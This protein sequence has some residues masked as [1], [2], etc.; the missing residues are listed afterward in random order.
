MRTD[1]YRY[2]TEPLSPKGKIAVYVFMFIVLCGVL[3]LL[4][5][6]PTMIGEMASTELDSNPVPTWTY[7]IVGGMLLVMF[8]GIV[9]EL[10]KASL[11]DVTDD[12]EDGTTDSGQTSR[13]EII[14][15][16]Y[17]SGDIDETEFKRQLDELE[18][19][20]SG[21]GVAT[22]RFDSHGSNHMVDRTVHSSTGLDPEAE[23]ILRRR[24]AEG[25]LTEQEY[26][27]KLKLLRE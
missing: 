25:T 10:Y 2:P 9:F 15:S 8:A 3:G 22:H 24:F 14:K 17:A 27:R 4:I 1:R 5:Y 11:L 19:P 13:V 23:E 20:P 7:L 12:A 26:K 6:L 21:T 16:R 18:G